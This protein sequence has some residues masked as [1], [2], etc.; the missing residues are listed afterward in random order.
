MDE[1]RPWLFVGRY[2]NSRDPD[3]LRRCQIKA[4]LHLA[5]DVRQPGVISLYLA[6]DDGVPLPIPA[7]QSGLEFIH[8]QKAMEHRVLVACG[9]GISRSVSFV[10]AALKEEEGLSL[11]DAYHAVWQVHPEA[12]PH[13]A[14]WQ[15]LQDYYHE[16]T[17]F[18]EVFDL[19]R[20]W[21]QA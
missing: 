9:A 6:V 12:M 15:S 3:L 5:E 14:L 1:V 16:D 2:L 18:G 19:L 4:M 13:P 11:V 7:L 17:S 10:I 20:Q 21:E 8:T